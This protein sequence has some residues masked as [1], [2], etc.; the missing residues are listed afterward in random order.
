MRNSLL[1]ILAIV[2]WMGCSTQSEDV[3]FDPSLSLV[4]SNDSVAFDTLLSERRSSTQRLTVY[5]PNDEAVQFSEIALGKDDA[6]DYSVII[7]G[8][9]SNS[10]SNERLAGGD[11]LLIL[12]EVNIAQRNQNLP[13]LVKDSIIFK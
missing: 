4:F 10:L 12:V 8:R 9:A 13:Y 2:I 6:S 11:S 1:I 3:S 5:N 7:N